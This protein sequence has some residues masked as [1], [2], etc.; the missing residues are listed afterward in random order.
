MVSALIETRHRVI[1][2]GSWRVASVQ[3]SSKRPTSCDCARLCVYQGKRE[4][5]CVPK[6]Q[7]PQ[8]AVTQLFLLW[9]LFVPGRAS[10]CAGQVGGC[11]QP[12]RA[13]AGPWHLTAAGEAGGGRSVCHCQAAAGSALQAVH[14][15]ETK[16]AEVMLTLEEALCLEQ[17]GAGFRNREA[18][19]AAPG[20]K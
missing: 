20:H 6:S 4:R 18:A 14:R 17:S 7:Q 8:I 10:R 2:Q 16:P 3:P 1:S 12:P 19:A 9:L 13:N 5:D 15:G 11:L